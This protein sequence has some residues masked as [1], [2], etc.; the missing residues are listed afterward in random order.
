[1]KRRVLIGS[2]LLFLAVVL[3]VRVVVGSREAQ[4]IAAFKGGAIVRS[5]FD[6]GFDYYLSQHHDIPEAW[7]KLSCLPAAM[8][9]Q[10]G[11]MPD[12]FWRDVS[13]LPGAKL[14]PAG[15]ENFRVWFLDE[16]ERTKTSGFFYQSP[17]V[18]K[19]TTASFE[20]PMAWVVYKETGRT[21]VAVLSY[22]GAMPAD[23]F[24]PFLQSAMNYAKAHGIHCDPAQLDYIRKF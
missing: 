9:E 19:G 6:S 3:G 15:I 24:I 21:R 18:P 13:F 23:D 12:S 17:Y 7:K 10:F 20:W 1:M 2:V 14:T 16:A 8:D 11:N 4:R 22:P 5:F